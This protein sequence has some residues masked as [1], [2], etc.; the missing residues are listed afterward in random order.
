MR[1]LAAGTSSDTR[2][3]ST[4]HDLTPNAKKPDPIGLLAAGAHGQVERQRAS[5]TNDKSTK[6]F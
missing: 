2:N 3:R 6:R 4:P 1:F 5:T